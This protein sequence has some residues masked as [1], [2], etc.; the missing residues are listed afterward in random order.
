MHK[1]LKHIVKRELNGEETIVIWAPRQRGGSRCVPLSFH[2]QFPLGLLSSWIT[3]QR[4]KERKKK[5]R[6]TRKKARIG[7]YRLL[8]KETS[9]NE[10]I[11]RRVEFYS[12]DYL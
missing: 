4:K 9:S 8:T 10:M 11:G 6:F 7:E 1:T 2:E 12:D 3:G 5:E